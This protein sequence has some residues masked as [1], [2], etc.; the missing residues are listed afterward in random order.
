M[1]QAGD[2]KKEI[3]D[4]KKRVKKLEERYTYDNSPDVLF[5]KAVELIK[6]YE[7]V[8]ASLLQRTL[9]IGY[10]RAA[11]ILDQLEE[12]G[13]VGRAEGGKPRKVIKK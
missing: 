7:E 8:S 4:L 2:L 13:F 3:E 9:V 5:E 1:D 12:K 11:R 10:S 6:G